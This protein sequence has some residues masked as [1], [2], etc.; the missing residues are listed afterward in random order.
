MD[1]L[2]T[3]KKILQKGKLE[4]WKV[5]NFLCQLDFKGNILSGV[6][7][8]KINKC[9]CAYLEFTRKFNFANRDIPVPEYLVPT[10]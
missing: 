2:G 4:F 7:I 10:E 8:P 3:E 5:T 1:F 6:R 9:C